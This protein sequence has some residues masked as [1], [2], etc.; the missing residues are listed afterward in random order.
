M[1]YDFNLTTKKIAFFRKKFVSSKYPL[2]SALNISLEKLYQFHGFT[3]QK[4]EFCAG[5]MV[6]NLKKYSIFVKNIFF[7]YDKNVKSITNNGDQTHINYEFQ[8][9]AKLKFIDYKFQT[10]W[11]YELIN[12]YPFLLSE[13][14]NKKFEGN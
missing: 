14:K 11:L 8:K 3:I 9:S 5:V 13:Y 7:K 1:P 6:Y 12:Y 10:I 2:N 4:D